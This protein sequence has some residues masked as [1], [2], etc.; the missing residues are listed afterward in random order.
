MANI[1]ERNG[2]YRIRVSAGLDSNKQQ[3]F[4]SYTWKPKAG[5]TDRQIEKELQRQTVMFEE[6]VK[7]GL[8][9]DEN[10]KF[11]E[12]ADI[13]LENEKPNL[14]P[15]TYNKYRDLLIRINSAIG[16]IKL[17]KLQSAHLK[18]FYR[19]LSETVSEKTGRKLSPQTVKHYHRCISAILTS[20]TKE[21][22]VT[23]NVASRFYMDAPKVPKKEPRHLDIESAQKFVSLLSEEDDI[24]VKTSLTMLIYSGIR[25]GELCGLEWGDIDFKNHIIHIRRAS[26]F[27]SG[28]GII[29]KPPKSDSAVRTIKLPEYVFSILLEYRKWYSQQKLLYGEDWKNSDRLFVTHDGAAIQPSRINRWLSDFIKKHDLPEITPHSLRHTFCTML[30]AD[31]V[32]IKT[33]SVKAGHSKTST[34]LDIYTHALKRADEI[35]STTLDRSLTPVAYREQA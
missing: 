7:R 23:R 34:T 18:A 33:V 19:Q 11:A 8:C 30:I 6:K 3:I 16:H 25:N 4:K 28:K 5:M 10:I 31:G 26:Q 21:E 17:S 9:I 22:I 32:D 13:W 24:R 14:A 12:Y 2:A 29:T 35:T 1:T 27:V 15:L 20:A